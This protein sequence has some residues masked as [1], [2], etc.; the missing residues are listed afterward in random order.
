MGRPPAIKLNR[1]GTVLI[2]LTRTRFEHAKIRARP[3]CRIEDFRTGALHGDGRL[4]TVLMLKRAVS[5]A[6]R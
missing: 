4:N 3:E 5:I 1:G 2:A 6:E